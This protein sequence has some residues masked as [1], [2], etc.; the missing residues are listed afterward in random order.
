MVINHALAQNNLEFPSIGP[1]INQ[2]KVTIDA[3][4]LIDFHGN[5]IQ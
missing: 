2:R 4:Y 3:H 5:A 1:A